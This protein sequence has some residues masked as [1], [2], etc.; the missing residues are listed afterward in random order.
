[1]QCLEV[2]LGVILVTWTERLQSAAGESSI[3]WRKRSPINLEVDA[4]AKR[5]PR[6]QNEKKSREQIDRP[7][8]E[9]TSVITRK[10]QNGRTWTWGER[11]VK[12]FIPAG[13]QPSAHL[14]QWI[15]AAQSRVQMF[16]V[17]YCSYIV[18]QTQWRK[19]VH[20]NKLR[21][22]AACSLVTWL[23][24]SPESVFRIP[25]IECVLK[26]KESLPFAQHYIFLAYPVLYL[27]SPLLPCNCNFFFCPWLRHSHLH[28][29]EFLYIQYLKMGRRQFLHYQR[30]WKISLD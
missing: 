18:T 1:M 28:Q 23:L 6:A 4:V 12:P 26:I 22:G 5:R 29:S 24:H 7:E 25:V 17:I 3:T 16:R 10:R 30:S 9:E 11:E 15:L 8:A 14:K 20:N 27:P 21:V 13:N 2:W 19:V